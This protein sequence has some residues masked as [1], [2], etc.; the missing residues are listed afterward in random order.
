[1]KST[2]AIIIEILRARFEGGMSWLEGRYTYH[3]TY[4][5]CSER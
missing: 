3:D 2:K 5:P 4:G 1:M